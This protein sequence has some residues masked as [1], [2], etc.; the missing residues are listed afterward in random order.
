MITPTPLDALGSVVSA[1]ERREA[2]PVAVAAVVIAA[3]RRHL[4]GESLDAAFR[5]KVR[6][7]GR[8]ETARAL[9]RFRQRDALIMEIWN[10]HQGRKTQRARQVADVITGRATIEDA[11]LA[12]VVAK[13][14]REFRADLPTSAKQIGRIADGEGVHHR[15]TA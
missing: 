10:A 1:L 3:W 6:Q 7:G 2:I 15:R 11:R 4:A 12:D 9:E 14:Q 5:A 13:L 8:Y